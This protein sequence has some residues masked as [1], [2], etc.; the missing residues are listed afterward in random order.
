MIY[1]LL[2]L[3]IYIWPFGQLLSL[4]VP[5]I[6][7]NLYLL[8][9]A[10]FLVFISLLVSPNRKKI[11]AG[12]ITKPLLIFLGIATVSLLL[13]FKQGVSSGFPLS[14]FYLTR[15]IIYPSIFYATRYIG[16]SRLKL[17]L[18]I[19]IVIFAL[20]CLAQYLVFP[21]MRYLKNLGFD[22]HYFRLIGSFY[23]PNF[24]GAVLAGTALFLIAKDKII[25]ALPFIALLAPTTSR[26]SYFVF[27]AGLIY[28]LFSK[29]KIKLLLLLVLLGVTIYLIPKPFGEGVNLLRTFSIYSR[30]GSWQQGLTLFSEK[31]LLGWGYNTLRGVDGSRFQTDSSYILILATTGVFGFL[32]FLNLLYKLYKNTV[33]WGAK[34]LIYSLLIHSLFNNSLFY[35][36]IFALFWIA[37]GLGQEKTKGYKSA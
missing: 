7:S 28:H 22:D 20:I 31:P 14:V 27:I 3:T 5:S 25:L 8:D 17:P 1:F 19:S 16:I 32:T 33:D 30:I 13:N 18:T 9:F 11:L 2:L 37:I 35:I 26:A 12:P 15:L 4:T 24:T 36:W 29:K 21:D 23:D 10:V 34:I 6:P